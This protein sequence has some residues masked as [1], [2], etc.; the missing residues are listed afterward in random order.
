MDILLVQNKKLHI[1][2]NHTLEEW[3]NQCG[4][5]ENLWDFNIDDFL[6]GAVEPNENIEYWW[7]DGR[8]YETNIEI[9]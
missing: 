8:L 4:D 5:D 6:Q 9:N 3:K 7:I 2:S 1:V